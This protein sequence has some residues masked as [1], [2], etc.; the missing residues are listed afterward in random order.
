[1]EKKTF[2]IRFFGKYG[3]LLQESVGAEA[4]YTLTN[5]EYVRAKIIQIEAEIVKTEGDNAKI[6]G[7]VAWTQPVRRKN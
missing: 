7:V 3:Q 2:L 1:V 4:V 6:D 5:E